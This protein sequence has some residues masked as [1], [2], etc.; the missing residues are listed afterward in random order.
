MG[1]ALIIRM[2][3][4]EEFALSFDSPTLAAKESALDRAAVIVQVQ[5]DSENAEL[6]LAQTELKTLL[7]SVEE[8]RVSI[9][10]PHLKRCDVIDTTVR[11]FLAEPKAEYERLRMVGGDYAALQIAKARAA[12]AVE[13]QRLQEAERQ[14]QSELSAAKT[15]D[16]MDAINEKHD[17]AA[18]Q[19]PTVVF[20]PVR[21]T[22]QSVTGDVDIEV[23][24]IHLL[25]KAHPTCVRMEPLKSEIKALHKAGVKVAG[26]RITEV[27]KSSARTARAINV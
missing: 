16:E 24:D 19:Q 10:A 4:A 1:E 7:R 25:A 6:A 9:K 26:V 13:N 2:P 27:M 18:R 22:G 17:I 20:A 21:P 8:M 15:H 5:T 12:Q 11:T 3:Q 14:R 23:F